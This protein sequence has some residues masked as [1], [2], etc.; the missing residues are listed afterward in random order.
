VEEWGK[1]EE[2]LSFLQI[3]GY[4]GSKSCFDISAG[5]PSSCS[6]LRPIAVHDGNIGYG[7]K[8]VVFA[9]SS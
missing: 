2:E 1:F 4:I 5:N 6:N 8:I 3:K 9:A 7:R